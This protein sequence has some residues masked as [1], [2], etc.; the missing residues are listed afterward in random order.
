MQKLSGVILTNAIKS[1]AQFAVVKG[2]VNRPKITDMTI[3]QLRAHARVC[4][5]RRGDHIKEGE[6]TKSRCIKLGQKVLMLTDLG[7]NTDR[8]AN[9]PLEQV[10]AVSAQLQE[11][12]DGGAMDKTLL[13]MQAEIAA[14]EQKAEPET[15]TGNADST[16]S[17]EESAENAE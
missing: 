11:A 10:D 7:V 15:E 6:Q 4:D 13:A 12:I 16:E 14:A 1:L 5:P 9:I 17:T 8:L 3:E 2:S